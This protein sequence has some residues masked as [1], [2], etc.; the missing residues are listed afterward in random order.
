LRNYVLYDFDGTL[1]RR[2]TT[3]FL[4]WAVWRNRPRRIIAAMP[5]IARMLLSR[6]RPDAFQS[7]K[8]RVLGTLMNGLTLDDL[9]AVMKAYRTSVQACIRSDVF[10]TLLAHQAQGTEILVVTASPRIAVQEVFA[11]H[12]IP[13]IGTEFQ[14]LQGRYTGEL[15]GRGC[16]GQ[17]KVPKVKAWI[18]SQANQHRIVEAWSD[19][20]SDAPMMLM[21]GR[22]F[23]VCSGQEAEWMTQ[24]DPGGTIFNGG[25]APIGLVAGLDIECPTS[26]APC[27]RK[28]A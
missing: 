27:E 10:A 14:S 12:G 22:R 16:Y 23:W 11:E 4:I 5:G 9:T 7:A 26:S 2:D 13:V 15:D 6:S 3:R 25:S 18:Q 8:F 24:R 19:S 28:Q 21:A 1:T 20:W 17:E